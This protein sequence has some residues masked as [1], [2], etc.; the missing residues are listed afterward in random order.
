VWLLLAPFILFYSTTVTAMV[1]DLIVGVVV[2]VLTAWAATVFG[3]PVP[4]A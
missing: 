3:R 4:Q 2:I 1:N